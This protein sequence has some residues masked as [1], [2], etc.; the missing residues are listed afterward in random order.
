VQ[1]EADIEHRKRNGSEPPGAAGSSDAQVDVLAGL[2]T[3]SWLDAQEF[4]PLSYAV[5]GVLP[6][7]QSLFVGP[8]KIGKSWC[9]LGFALAVAAR[10][11]TLGGIELSTRPVLDLALEDGDRR[12]QERYRK[13]M[14]GEPIPARFRIRHPRDARAGDHCHRGVARPPPERDADCNPRHP[15]NVMPPASAMSLATSVTIAWAPRSSGC[16]TSGPAFACSSSTATARPTRRT[17]LT[18]VGDARARWRADTI[19]VL[20]RDRHETAAGLVVMA[21]GSAALMIGPA[22]PSLQTRFSR[23]AA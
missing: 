17:S 1:L 22:V 7:G 9:V 2:R 18:R 14:A 21:V 12:L 5:P 13:V 10:G 11:R 16:A 23:G 15:G 19:L 3:G 20:T 4:P 8:P 6:E